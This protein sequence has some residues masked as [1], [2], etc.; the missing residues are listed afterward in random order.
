MKSMRP[1]KSAFLHAVDG[2]A[3][4]LHAM[5]DEDVIH[6]AARFAVMLCATRGID[7]S[8]VAAVIETWSSEIDNA[9]WKS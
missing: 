4:Y 1:W 9:W 2:A 8:R 5:S 7:K 3:D 6:V